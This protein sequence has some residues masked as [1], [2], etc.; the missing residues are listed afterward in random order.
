MSE[1]TIK[2]DRD[3]APS[4]TVRETRD[5]YA[6]AASQLAAEAGTDELNH[7]ELEVTGNVSPSIQVKYHPRGTVAIRVL[8]AATSLG[9]VVTDSY[10]LHRDLE[11]DRSRLR[12]KFREEN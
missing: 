3:S 8:R 9:L 11:D 5:R 4:K 10:Q 12:F 1:A 7:I 2:Y 6:M